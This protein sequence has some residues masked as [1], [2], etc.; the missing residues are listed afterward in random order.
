MQR[1]IKAALLLLYILIHT[2]GTA[3]AKDH[4]AGMIFKEANNFF[5]NQQYEEARAQYE[6]LLKQ[7]YFDP[8]LLFNLS[9][10]YLFL[11]MRAQAALNLYRA[12]RL[13]PRSEDIAKNIQVIN[14]LIYKGT[15]IYEAYMSGEKIRYDF[16]LKSLIRSFTLM[17]RNE[18]A[19]SIFLLYLLF[20]VWSLLRKLI[21]PG[22]PRVFF[23]TLAAL[24]Y[25][26]SI[27]LITIFIGTFY[28]DAFHPQTVVMETVELKSSPSEDES[29][30]SSI[31]VKEGMLLELI[32]T[33]DNWGEVITP[34]DNETGWI[35]LELLKKL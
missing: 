14:T 24:S 23:G 7:G 1:I 33:Y 13:Q 30:N 15:P 4:D 21:K 8:S 32:R 34:Y 25:L 2:A 29:Y 12:R 18:L 5:L 28:L 11:D 16:S 26:F 35:K 19:I 17:S 31:I 10:T 20:V 3:Y 27:L 9:S 6:S 22:L